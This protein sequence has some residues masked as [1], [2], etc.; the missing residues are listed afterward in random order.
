M[1]QV[2]QKANPPKEDRRRLTKILFDELLS[3][4]ILWRAC[5][6]VQL[7]MDVVDV[8]APNDAWPHLGF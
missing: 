3:E 4:K 7:G 6:L 1:G 2:A 8:G 5:E